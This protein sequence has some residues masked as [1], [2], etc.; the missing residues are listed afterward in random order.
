METES[1]S[2]KIKNKIAEK[3]DAGELK[4][5]ELMPSIRKFSEMERVSFKTSVKIYN[6]LEKDGYIIKIQGKGTFVKEFTSHEKKLESSLKSYVPRTRFINNINNDSGSYRYHFIDTHQSNYLV[7]YDFINQLSEDIDR[8][9]L[10]NYAHP[11]GHFELRGT[12]ADLL[13]SEDINVN[14]DQMMITNGVQQG[15]NL[16]A[17]SFIGNGENLAIADLSFPA[18]ADVFNWQG[19]NINSL[20]IEEDGLSISYLNSI[21]L[22]KKVKFLYVMPNFNNPTGIMM[23][24]EKKEELLKLS[25]DHDFYIIEDDSWGDLYTGKR[26]AKTLKSMDAMGRVIYLKGFT[27]TLGAGYRIGV[28]VA[29]KAIIGELT[30]AKVL[31]DLGSPIMTQIAVNSILKSNMYQRHLKKIRSDLRDRLNLSEKIFAKHMPAYVKYKIPDGGPN[32]WIVLP[33]H[34]DSRYYLE[35][36][37]QIDLNFALGN[38]YY[39]SKVKNNTIRLSIVNIKFEDLQ[40]GLVR[41]CN[42]F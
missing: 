31:S 24:M 28:I 19:A 38:V 3:I 32:I 16:I 27:K 33:E 15:I 7:P 35:L 5:G 41:F 11:L 20:P 29:D 9:I 30:G 34:Y 4:T 12:I 22:K 17:R 8:N 39:T 40:E 25:I 36:A 2:K 23:S 6:Q 26:K 21:C 10:S 14:I 37:N 42:L 1:L 18:A 13:N